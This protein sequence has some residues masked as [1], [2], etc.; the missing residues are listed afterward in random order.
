MNIA[1]L[2]T[3]PNTSSA[4]DKNTFATAKK[5]VLDGLKS[6]GIEDTSDFVTAA[7][8]LLVGAYAITMVI[9]LIG[10]Y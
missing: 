8:Y 7:G 10:Q 4:D 6:F 2:K 5:T 3:N 9:N 1:N